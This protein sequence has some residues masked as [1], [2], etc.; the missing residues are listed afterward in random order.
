[1]KPLLPTGGDGM[2]PRSAEAPGTS[3]AKTTS[4]EGLGGNPLQSQSTG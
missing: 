2:S 1:M 3:T 4:S